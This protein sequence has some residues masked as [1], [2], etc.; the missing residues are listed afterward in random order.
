MGCMQ[1]V[2]PN[3]KN[4]PHH[5]IVQAGMPPDTDTCEQLRVFAKAVTDVFKFSDRQ[6]IC[7]TACHKGGAIRT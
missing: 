5:S 6:T 3:T 4:L 1:W 7:S 2:K